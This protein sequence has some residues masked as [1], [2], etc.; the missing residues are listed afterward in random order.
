MIDGSGA[1]VAGL[2]AALTMQISKNGGAFSPVGGTIG[3]ISDG[4]YTY[5]STAGEADTVGP[6]AFTAI[7]AGTIQQNLEYVV[8]ARNINGVEFTYTVTDSVTTDPIPGVVVSVS[9]DIAGNNVIFNGQTDSFGV[10]RHLETNELPFLDPGPYYF[11][12]RKSGYS[13]VNP[14][15]ENVS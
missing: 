11:W 3:E 2:G 12:S 14:D 13:F 4:W 8:A 1:E 5:L 7:G 15:L 10:L 9:T 6:V